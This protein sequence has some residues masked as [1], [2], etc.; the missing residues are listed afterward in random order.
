MAITGHLHLCNSGI[1]KR[2]AR[3]FSQS[4]EEGTIIIKPKNIRWEIVAAIA[5]IL[6]VIVA[7]SMPFVL[8]NIDNSK[9]TVI[10]TYVFNKQLAADEMSN[11]EIIDCFNSGEGMRQDSL[12]CTNEHQILAPC[13]PFYIPTENDTVTCPDK[14]HKQARIYRQNKE[15]V[16]QETASD[17]RD[18]L[19]GAQPDPWYIF[20]FSGEECKRSRGAT[21][22]VANKRI[23]FGC[24]KNE[25]I[26]YLPVVNSG[27]GVYVISCLKNNVIQQCAI[28]E[29]WL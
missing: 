22:V 3:L 19:F 14:P 17:N 18:R 28:K 11:L 9:K 29:M 25:T 2:K 4:Q 8:Q 21:V 5:A 26:L 13:F 16:E 23:D 15:A 20:L 24:D 6:S 12:A 1:P 27:D 10:N 7:I